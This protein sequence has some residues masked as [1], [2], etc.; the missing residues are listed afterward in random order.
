MCASSNYN[1]EKRSRFTHVKWSKAFS[2][3]ISP[4]VTRDIA[5]PFKGSEAIWDSACSRWDSTACRCLKQSSEQTLLV[6]C[7]GAGKG[8][9]LTKQIRRNNMVVMD[10]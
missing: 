10:P 1:P 5:E 4:D 7:E 9:T 3:N 2:C 6:H 8:Q